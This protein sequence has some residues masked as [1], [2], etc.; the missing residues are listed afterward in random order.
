MKNTF[1]DEEIEIIFQAFKRL[2]KISIIEEDQ[3]LILI[4]TIINKKAFDLIKALYD[5]MLSDDSGQS[6]E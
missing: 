4:K 3:N 6:L 2:V 5:K 1:N